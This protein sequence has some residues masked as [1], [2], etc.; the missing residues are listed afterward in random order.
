VSDVGPYEQLAELAERELA[1]VSAFALE[2]LGELVEIDQQRS[3]LVASLPERP[4]AEARMPLAR[5]A[6]LQ[7]RTTA[8]LTQLLAQLGHELGEVDRGRR[9][10]AGYALQAP[11]RPV[12]DRAG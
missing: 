10:A 6:A 8:A 12:L 4:P 5:A 7:R 1:I 3:R 2:R 11:V 9:A